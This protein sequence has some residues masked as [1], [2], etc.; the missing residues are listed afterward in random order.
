V[1]HP[2]RFTRSAVTK[3]Y[4]KNQKIKE[5]IRVV[6]CKGGY[7]MKYYNL[8]GGGGEEEEDDEDDE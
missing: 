3:K 4:I 6:S 7:E 8:S 1:L 5:F 2:P